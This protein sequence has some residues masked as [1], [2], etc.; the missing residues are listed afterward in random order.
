[1]RWVQSLWGGVDS[2]VGA[3]F[4]HRVPLTCRRGSV[5]AKYLA[6]Y[7]FARPDTHGYGG[8]GLDASGFGSFSRVGGEGLA[9]RGVDVADGLWRGTTLPASVAVVEEIG[10]PRVEAGGGDLL[11][12]YVPEVGQCMEDQSSIR[13]AGAG[14]AGGLR[15]D[16][17]TETLM[18]HPSLAESLVDAAE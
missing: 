6:E 11:Q 14:G 7:V 9:D 3:R 5:F 17:L 18:V 15:T 4:P 2:W 1:M 8:G 12:R 10:V 16:V 13:D